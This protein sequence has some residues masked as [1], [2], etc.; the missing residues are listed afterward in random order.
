MSDAHP[1]IG[2][3]G[4]FRALR[5]GVAARRDGVPLEA[6]PY[7]L[8]GPFEQRVKAR[9]WVRGWTRANSVMAKRGLVSAEGATQGP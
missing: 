1:R 4:A 6:C 9:Y 7:D 3:I 2:R 8:G 5:A